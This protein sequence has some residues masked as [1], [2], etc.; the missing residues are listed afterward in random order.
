[1]T[2][3]AYMPCTN[4]GVFGSPVPGRD[5]VSAASEQFLLEASAAE[6]AGFDGI[7]VPERHARVETFLPSPLV[8]LAAL[9]AR[10]KRVS[11]ATT[12]MVPTYYNPMLVAESLA[13][14]DQLSR[15]RLV[16]GAGV[17]YHEDYFRLFGVP[18]Y[19]VGAR[20]EES[21]EVIRR[22][23]TEERVTF[24]GEFFQFDDVLMTPKPYQRPRP[25]VWI[26]AHYDK[27]IRR[28]LDW[29]GWCWWFPQP[30]DAAYEKVS[31]WRDEAQKRR[32]HSN[33]TVALCYEGWVGDET[34]T[35]RATHVQRWDPVTKFLADRSVLPGSAAGAVTA[36]EDSWLILG[37]S[38]YWVERIGRVVDRV[39]PDWICIRTRTPGTADGPRN[40]SFA[41]SL[42]VIDRFGREVIRHF[43]H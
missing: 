11:L 10:T 39:R 4:F 13:Q 3:F 26:G 31:F 1:V 8:L 23:W 38:D 42:E 12:V 17:G 18:K 6:E 32:G 33:W 43:Q 20:F 19:R 35:V 16:F 25:P 2:R 22:A 28:A 14:I 34:A 21:M 36:P 41:E 7:W 5:L 15:G 30:L 37:D 29:E 24:K 27:A 9:A 40:P